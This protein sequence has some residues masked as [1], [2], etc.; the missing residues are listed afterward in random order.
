MYS[1]FPIPSNYILC[2]FCLSA[3]FK[4]K[5]YL[6]VFHFEKC[7]LT[8]GRTFVSEYTR[9]L[10]LKK[11]VVEFQAAFEMLD[12]KGTGKISIAQLPNTIRC[13]D[14]TAKHADINNMKK[15]L[16][17]D[18]INSNLCQVVCYLNIRIQRCA[19]FTK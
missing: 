2:V 16:D 12:I 4:R 10:N 5:V 11:I 15:L 19:S 18:G 9:H 17:K 14:P 7:G 3:T 8:T 13:L 1:P 6:F